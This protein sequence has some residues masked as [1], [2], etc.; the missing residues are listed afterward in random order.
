[1]LPDLRWTNQLVLMTRKTAEGPASQLVWSCRLT[2]EPSRIFAGSVQSSA[3]LFKVASPVP[4][5]KPAVVYPAFVESRAVIGV[6]SRTGERELPVM[7]SAWHSKL[8]P[9]SRPQQCPQP[10]THPYLSTVRLF[11]LGQSGCML[12]W[13]SFSTAPHKGAGHELFCLY[14][15]WASCWKCRKQQ[16]WFTMFKQDGIPQYPQ[17]SSVLFRFC[18]FEQRWRPHLCVLSYLGQPSSSSNK[19]A[20]P[21]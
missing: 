5:G 18:F 11:P 20:A 14:R 13:F 4:Q 8:T 7:S 9:D 15:E 1:M 6:G 19:Y 2:D 10:K 16:R 17:V 21:D 12:C 3:L